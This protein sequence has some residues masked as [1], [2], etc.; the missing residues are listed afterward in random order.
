MRWVNFLHIYQPPSQT[1]EIIRRV[2]EESYKKIVEQ[3]E[4]APEGKLTINISGALTELLHK[5]G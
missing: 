5:H 3:L 4:L 1:P 2:T